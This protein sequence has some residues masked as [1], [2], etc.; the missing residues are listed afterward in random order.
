MVE[1]IEDF[2]SIEDRL[3]K[4]EDKLE[5]GDVWDFRARLLGLEQETLALKRKI[6]QGMISRMDM[7][8]RDII[9]QH[10]HAPSPPHGLLLQSDVCIAELQ[11]LGVLTFERIQRLETEVEI[12]AALESFKKDVNETLGGYGFPQIRIPRQYG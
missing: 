1:D 6:Y 9:H 12:Q 7:M 2:L 5:E 8:T 10:V 4:L 3:K 11:T